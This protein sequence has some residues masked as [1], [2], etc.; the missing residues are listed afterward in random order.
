M[1]IRPTSKWQ[2][3]FSQEL[4]PKMSEQLILRSGEKGSGEKGKE[5]WDF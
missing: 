3:L 4:F 1:A 2:E 5:T